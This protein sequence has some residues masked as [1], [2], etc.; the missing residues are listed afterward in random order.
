MCALS[1]YIAPLN[2]PSEVEIGSPFH[3][4]MNTLWFLTISLFVMFP[5]SAGYVIQCFSPRWLGVGLTWVAY[6][7]F[8]LHDVNFQLYTFVGTDSPSFAFLIFLDVLQYEFI[9]N[10]YPVLVVAALM[11]YGN[12]PFFLEAE[13]DGDHGK[14]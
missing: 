13:G 10:L 8:I 11:T 5:V 12:A 14:Q 2:S 6:R 7:T 4:A 3:M 1:N 9:G